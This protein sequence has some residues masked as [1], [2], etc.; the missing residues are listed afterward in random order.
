MASTDVGADL[1][2]G[3]LPDLSQ[4]PDLSHHAPKP[5]MTRQLSRFGGRGSVLCLCAC[6]YRKFERGVC[7]FL[8]Q[9]GCSRG[10]TGLSKAP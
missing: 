1:S 5:S 2:Q 3:P 9:I 8:M 7:C 6:D 4:G 10:P